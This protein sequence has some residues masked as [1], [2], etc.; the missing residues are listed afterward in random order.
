M[1]RARSLALISSVPW[2]TCPAN[3]D[4]LLSEEVI[5]QTLA[6]HWQ[7]PFLRIDLEKL[8]PRLATS[9]ISEPF[10]TKHLTIPLSISKRMLFVAVINPL[11]V[12]ALDMLRTASNLKVR[13]VISTKTDI[14][15]AIEKCY[16]ASKVANAPEQG[17]TEKFQ[18]SIGAVEKEL[19]P[20]GTKAKFFW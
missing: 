3:A 15:K 6:S 20:K 8:N 19:S 10:A 7:L 4:L 1:V 12:E 18:V 11:D 17:L 13:P 16:K 5:M 14:L 9:K 2:I